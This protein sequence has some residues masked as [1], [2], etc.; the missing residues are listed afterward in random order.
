MLT[1]IREPIELM[2]NGHCGRCGVF[3]VRPVEQ[4]EYVIGN[5]RVITPNMP[6]R[7]KTVLDNL[8]NHN[9]VTD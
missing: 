6:P 5:V 8:M 9:G 4:A 3:A 7:V 1:T 2:V